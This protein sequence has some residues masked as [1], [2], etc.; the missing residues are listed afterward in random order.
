MRGGHFC[1]P[2]LILNL[3]LTIY[4]WPRGDTCLGCAVEQNAT[5]DVSLLMPSNAESTLR[6]REPPGLKEISLVS[7][8][9]TVFT[10]SPVLNPVPETA[11]HTAEMSSTSV[12]FTTPTGEANRRITF[13]VDGS[14]ISLVTRS[15]L[16]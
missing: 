8:C 12:T 7:Y 15:T 13:P 6:V 4:H 16:S 11:V 3:D 2:P 10:A 5:E 9:V 1:P 14:L